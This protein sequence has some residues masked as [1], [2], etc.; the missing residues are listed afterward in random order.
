MFM[1]RRLDTP[2]KISSSFSRRCDAV[3]GGLQRSPATGAAVEVSTTGADVGGGSAT[4]VGGEVVGVLAGALDIFGVGRTVELRVGLGVGFGTGFRVGASIGEPE[5]AYVVGA[6]ELGEGFFDGSGV[7][8]GVGF[9]V[10]FGVGRLVGFLVGTAEGSPTGR[11][12]GGGVTGG[13]VCE[14]G[15]GVRG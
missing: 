2:A 4:L 11:F 3:I 12:V 7:G 15:L 5:G 6:I 8:L 14:T 10:G 13:Q 1:S 9:L